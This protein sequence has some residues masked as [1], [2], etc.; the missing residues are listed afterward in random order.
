MKYVSVVAT[1]LIL[2]TGLATLFGMGVMPMREA[3]AAEI[4]TVALKSTKGGCPGGQGFCCLFD[5]RRLQSA[6]EGVNGVSE[7]IPDKK[8]KTFTVVY[9]KE[10]EILGDLKQAARQAGFEIVEARKIP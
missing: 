8:A 3:T 7:V 1:A 10:R 6:L 4:E 2:T 9:E 5:Q